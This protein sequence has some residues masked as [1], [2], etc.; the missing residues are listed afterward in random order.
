[1]VLPDK[2]LLA[3]FTVS[4]PSLPGSAL[5]QGL[6]N[7]TS[8]FCHHLAGEEAQARGGIQKKSTIDFSLVKNSHYQYSVN[9]R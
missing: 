1:M 7:S 4:T 9:V 5:N 6:L 8:Y 2:S 3:Q